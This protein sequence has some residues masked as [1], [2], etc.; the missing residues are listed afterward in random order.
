MRKQKKKNSVRRSKSKPKV[1]PGIKA[2]VGAKS[3]TRTGELR[4]HRDGYGFVIADHLGDED[5]FVPARYMDD[6]LHGDL[7]E[8]KIRPGRGGKL[9]GRILNIVGRG[10]EQLIGRFES[11]G[12][13]YRVV[14][15][16]LR[17]RHRVVIPTR[18]V[19]GAKHGDN[20][21]VRIVDYPRG[22]DGM[23]GEV[24]EVLGKRGEVNTEKLAIII[25]HQLNRDFPQAV[26]NEAEDVSSKL[27]DVEEGEAKGDRR[28]LTEIPF[29]T[30]DG[31]TAK[32]FD[33]A[34]A[35]EKL[36]SGAIRLWVSI[37][38]VSFFV[39]PNT[40]L[41]DEAYARATSTY[42]P[43]DCIPMLP[44]ALSN[45]LCSLREGRARY[46]MTAEMD[47]SPEGRITSSCFYRSLIKSRARMTYKSIK[48]ILVDRKNGT[49]N[50]YK[51]LLPQFELMEECFGRLRAARIKRGT[52]DFDLP[53]PEIVIDMQGDISDIVR[54]NRHI[55]HMMIEEFMIAANES[56]AEF[57]TEWGGGCIYRVHE[58][59]RAE[60]L[61]E[62]SL[63]IHNLG[64]KASVKPGA[65][66]SKL[67]KVLKLIKGR[68]E[69]RMVNHAMLRSLSQA[70]YS[71]E[72]AGHYGLAS[73]CYCHFTSPIRRYPDLIT[74]R[75][76]SDAISR[77]SKKRGGRSRHQPEIA[78][79]DLHFAAEHCSRRERVSVGAERDIAKLYAALFMQGRIDESFDGIISHIAKFGFFVELIDFF[80]EGLVPIATLDD[81]RYWFDE[82]GMK[83]RGKRGGKSFAIG[84]RVR[85]SVAEVDVSAGEINFELDSSGEEAL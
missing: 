7:V 61:T 66:P 10:V 51:E 82:K 79:R 76:L 29:V 49:R 23:T 31:V 34:V 14:A 25:K 60:K 33:D 69:E 9:E 46:T 24:V 8:V 19:N 78:S 54:A 81:D 80:V 5:V 26:I 40:A 4:M 38:D 21:V 50:R 37:A 65:A 63:L 71:C 70:V 85:I 68:P 73:K 44:E 1:K 18:A 72:N 56:V 12:G 30:I 2:K 67:A 39:R 45:D 3:K 83:I 53:E 57:L 15:D 59:P 32:D 13:S 28:D 43:S 77:V 48:E 64:I 74:H 11:H 62:F 52:L 84:D 58:P 75:L 17:V 6:A 22:E 36:E 20:V 55:G 35:V 42:F 27:T 41:D 47:I 16:D